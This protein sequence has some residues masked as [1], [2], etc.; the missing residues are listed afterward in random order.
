[1][2][3]ATSS[4]AQHGPAGYDRSQERARGMPEGD[5]ADLTEPIDWAARDLVGWQ[6]KERL[7]RP[8]DM[9]VGSP[10]CG[11]RVVGSGTSRMEG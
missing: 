7:G 10:P 4:L 1:M 8:P 5:L 6:L 9:I 2:P 11:R 3:I